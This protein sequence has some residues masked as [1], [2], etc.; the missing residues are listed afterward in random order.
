MTALSESLAAFSIDKRPFPSRAT[1]FVRK[2]RKSEAL[3]MTVL[4]ESLQHSWL[5]MLNHEKRKKVMGF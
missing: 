3:S 1:A 5:G 4:S 2:R